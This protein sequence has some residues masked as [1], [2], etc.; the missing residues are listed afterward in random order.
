LEDSSDT[1]DP[2]SLLYQINAILGEVILPYFLQGLLIVILLLL[3]GFI[4]AMEYALLSVSNDDAEISK[5]SNLLADKRITFLLHHKKKL[6]VSLSIFKN[7]I[8]LSAASLIFYSIPRQFKETSFS[9]I[10]YGTIILLSIIMVLVNEIMPRTVVKD[11]YSTAKRT[12][13]FLLIIYKTFNPITKLLIRLN[14]PKIKKTSKKVG[15]EKEEILEEGKK[16][17]QEMFEEEDEVV[18][19][20][21]HLESL[22]L[23]KIMINRLDIQAFDWDL[24]FEE[25]LKEVNEHGFSRIPVFK[26]NIDHIEGILYVKDLLIHL[27]EKSTFDWHKVIRPGFFIP[28]SKK[29]DDLLKEFQEK[30]VHMAIIV[31][32]YGGTSG[33]ITMEDILEEI[34]GD[35]NDEFDNNHELTYSTLDENT[36][37]FEGDT[38]LSEFFKIHGIEDDFTSVGNLEEETLS[39]FIIGFV[40]RLPSIGE[41]I[42]FHKFE[43]T[44]LG[45]EE[46]SIS[47]VKVNIKDQSNKALV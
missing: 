25:V 1:A 37:I 2:L 41:Q 10:F 45:I 40:D 42:Y 20:T 46:K 33:L 35:I 44:I 13:L 12:S 5:K 47:R 8:L 17:R 38:L 7:I 36:F 34:V 22:S 24:S 43:F 27:E 14:Y 23:K 3:T 26:E 18:P 30:K 16:D 19:T 15:D 6:S 32:E 11:V 28:E 9:L 4:S 29:I 21:P 39:G 31:D